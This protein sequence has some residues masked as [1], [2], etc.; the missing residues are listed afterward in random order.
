MKRVTWVSVDGA[1]APLRGDELE[2]QESL[3]LAEEGPERMAR[4][5]RPTS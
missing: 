1:V 5:W 3:I 4:A 2:A